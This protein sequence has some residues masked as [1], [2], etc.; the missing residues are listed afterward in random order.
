MALSPCLQSGLR[1]IDIWQRHTIKTNGITT[2]IVNQLAAPLK[3]GPGAVN[4][5]SAEISLSEQRIIR[6]P[7]Q[8]YRRLGLQGQAVIGSHMQ[9]TSILRNRLGRE[10]A[11]FLAR[12]QVDPDSGDVDWYASSSGNLHAVAELAESERVQVQTLAESLKREILQLADKLKREG[13]SAE[14]V[15]RMLEQAMET[16]AGNWLYESQGKPI[17]VMWGHAG[18][19]QFSDGN[20]P[21]SPPHR[22]APPPQSPLPPAAAPPP[23]AC[24]R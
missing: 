18:D 15:G 2:Y 13:Q 22:I 19:H 24:S 10:H 7:G 9:I 1:W 5:I 14:L 20:V 8:G 3:P 17:L 16:P 21:T 4:L 12:P 11:A 23:A 6:S